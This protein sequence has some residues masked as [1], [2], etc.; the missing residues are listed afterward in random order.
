MTRFHRVRSDVAHKQRHGFSPKKF[1][2]AKKQDE[3]C[4][5][6]K[7]NRVNS[8]DNVITHAVARVV[9]FR[10]VRGD[11]LNFLLALNRPYDTW[12]LCP[13]GIKR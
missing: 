5:R 12:G 13:I 8:C 10:A 2:V 1:L 3:R 11:I 6:T 9:R 7:L 4:L